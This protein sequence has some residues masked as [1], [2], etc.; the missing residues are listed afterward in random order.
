MHQKGIPYN[1]IGITCHG[2]NAMGSTHQLTSTTFNEVLKHAQDGKKVHKQKFTNRPHDRKQVGVSWTFTIYSSVNL[3]AIIYG[4]ATMEQAMIS[5]YPSTPLPLP[6]F[7]T[8]V[9]CKDI[10]FMLAGYNIAIVK[11]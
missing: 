4:I 3:Q 11:A 9:G 8:I 1:R 5:K 10:H 6:S 2:I 7:V